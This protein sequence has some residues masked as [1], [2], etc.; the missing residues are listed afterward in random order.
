[1]GQAV[2]SRESSRERILQGAARLFVA[3]GYRGLSMREI[4]DEVGVSKPAIYHHFADKE[5]LF[6]A[7][8]GD[9][10]DHL[11]AVIAEAR[12]AGPP[13]R[14]C[15]GRIV[16]GLLARRVEQRAVLRLA[17]QELVHLSAATQAQFLARYELDFTGAIR[18]V[19]AAGVAA[20]EF[21]P[22]S[23]DTATWALLG[24]LYPYFSSQNAPPTEIVD[25][26]LGIYFEGIGEQ[27]VK[28]FKA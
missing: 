20:G 11:A 19:V 18:E 2:T 15:L 28:D 6:V 13:W 21:R 10:V 4:A 9:A 16:G 23:P 24:M 1:M 12:A 5:Q 17:T 3:Q 25:E 7:V 26:L 14:A 22:V 27:Q 8:L